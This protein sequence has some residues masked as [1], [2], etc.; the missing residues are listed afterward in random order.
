MSELKLR[1]RYQETDNMGVVYHSNYFIWY[2][3][4]RTEFL[5][6]HGC[7]YKNLEKQGVFFV[8]AE[9][10]NKYLKS[11]TFDDGLLIKTTL[12]ELKNVSVEFSY[13]VF[14]QESGEKVSIGWTKLAVVDK[15]GRVIKMPPELLEKLKR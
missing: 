5:R 4:A 13:E 1:V 3:L 11:L 14:N 9:T 12:G 8:V 10:S 15:N 6:E 7:S 2:D